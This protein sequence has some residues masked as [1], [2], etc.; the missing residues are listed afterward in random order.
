VGVGDL[1]SVDP[2]DDSSGSTPSWSKRSCSSAAFTARRTCEDSVVGASEG[3]NPEFRERREAWE[4]R[5]MG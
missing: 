4:G 2:L 3:A 5:R 1:S